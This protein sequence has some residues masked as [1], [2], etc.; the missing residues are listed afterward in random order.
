MVYWPFY[1]S[2][3]QFYLEI[4]NHCLRFCVPTL[5]NYQQLTG[6]NC[7]LLHLYFR[8]FHIFFLCY[9]N[10]FSLVILWQTSR[11]STFLYPYIITYNFGYLLILNIF[12]NFLN[13]LYILCIWKFIFSVPPNLNSWIRPWKSSKNTKCHIE[14]TQQVLN[15]IKSAVITDDRT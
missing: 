4:L 5:S 2:S 11:Y 9:S 12:Y 8:C 13:I 14:P 7:I 3:L 15:K 1:D 6:R 10:R